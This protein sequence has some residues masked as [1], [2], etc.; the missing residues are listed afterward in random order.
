MIVVY[1]L[2]PL[3]EQPVFLSAEPFLQPLY[4]IFL[5]L[6]FFFKLG[7]PNWLDWLANELHGFFCLSVFS[8]VGL[9]MCTAVSGFSIGSQGL[10]SSHHACCVA[11]IL[12]TGLSSSQ[13]WDCF[14]IIRKTNVQRTLKEVLAKSVCFESGPWTWH[15][16]WQAFGSEEGERW[17]REEGLLLFADTG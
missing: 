11:C 3:K 6:G 5:R 10:R 12:P 7:F 4:L 13:P 16:T 2:G 9:Q 8:S 17:E 15:L 14:L 1:H